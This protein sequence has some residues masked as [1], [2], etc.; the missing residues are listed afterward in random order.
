[1]RLRSRGA[2]EWVYRDP[3]GRV[4]WRC[5]FPNGTTYAGV[6][7]LLNAAFRGA[8]QSSSWYLGV[9]D[10]TGFSGLDPA[11]TLAAHAGWSEFTAVHLGQRPA[12]TPV[13]ANGG[14][15]SYTTAALFQFTAAGTVR[16]AFLCDRLAVGP[17]SG[18]LY[19]TGALAAGRA[20]AA[21]GTLSVGYK[22]RLSNS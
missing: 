6:N 18:V 9:I 15:T 12:W 19:C 17:G 1:M 4:G 7:Y 21:G 2:F 11:D 22:A 16:G 5:A 13:A 20:V 10:D 14:L 3:A 8:A